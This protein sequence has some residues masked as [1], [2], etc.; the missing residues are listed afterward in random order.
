M[1]RRGKRSGRPTNP[2]PNHMNPQWVPENR[3]G[4]LESRG[5]ATRRGKDR[6]SAAPLGEPVPGN[7]TLP[8]F[9]LIQPVPP[10]KRLPAPWTRKLPQNHSPQKRSYA[11][12][13]KGKPVQPVRSRAP[14]GAARRKHNTCAPARNPGAP[15]K[16]SP[17]QTAN[18]EFGALTRK[19]H[20][21]IKVVHHL[22]NID[23]ELTPKE[24]AMIKRMM[25]VLSTFIKPAVPNPETTELIIDNAG[26]WADT[27]LEILEK[28]Y[29]HTLEGILEGLGDHITPDWRTCFEVAC[30]WA[31]KNLPR[32][33][34][35]VM[36]HAE[37]LIIT[38][39]P[40]SENTETEEEDR[41]DLDPPREIQSGSTSPQ[42][43]DNTHPGKK[44]Q[45]RQGDNKN[46]NKKTVS[47]MTVNAEDWF[48]GTGDST[49]VG[50]EW[51]NTEETPRP[52]RV[53][54]R[55]NQT[56]RVKIQLDKK[57]HLNGEE[58]ENNKKDI[59]QK[60]GQ[61]TIP[62]GSPKPTDL[63]AVTAG[64]GPKLRVPTSSRGAIT[65]NP[66]QTPPKDKTQEGTVSMTTEDPQTEI[67]NGPKYLLRSR[68]KEP[69]KFIQYKD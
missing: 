7:V 52:P 25:D 12:V 57:T 18:P 16:N 4:S 5:A 42:V 9:T 45:H 54:Q 29:T 24:P 33:K 3:G 13:I 51:F 67:Q 66:S 55:G 53:S 26:R 15:M 39:I 20:T 40:Q 36:D 1:V 49:F 58:G 32:I 43:A 46:N 63:S 50:Q 38:C 68:V 35:Q 48:T 60:E 10:S 47:T 59:E 21:I 65:G 17:K 11:A 37:A 56:M 28:H 64:E 31:R 30:R 6:A 44:Q 8:G 14:S 23:P 62:E 61:T 19:F 22:Q 2:Y 34:Q 27:T 41:I 69:P